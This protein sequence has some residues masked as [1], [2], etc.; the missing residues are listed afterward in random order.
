MLINLLKKHYKLFTIYLIFTIAIVLCAIIK[1]DYDVIIPAG[2]ED[3]GNAIV[4]TG[5]SDSGIDINTVSVYSYSKIS[6][7]DYLCAKLNKNDTVEK[8]YEYNVTDLDLVY[9]SGNIQKKVSINNSIIAGYKAAGCEIEYT[10]INTNGCII[11][12]LATYAPKELQIGD[13]I[14]AVNGEA[15]TDKVSVSVLIRKMVDFSY[16][17]VDEKVLVEEEGLKEYPTIFTV[18]RKGTKQNITCYPYAYSN[19]Y[20]DNNNVCK[21]PL[22]GISIYE[23]NIIKSTNPEYKI[24]PVSS[25]GPSGGL[26]QSFYVYEVLTGGKLSKDLKIVGTGTVDKDGNAGAIGGIYQKVIA[27]HLNKADIFFVP[28]SSMDKE[29]YSKESNYTEA[30]ASY[31][32]LGNTKMKLVPVASLNDIIEYLTNYQGGK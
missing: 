1:V 5:K 2:T 23:Y 3:V 13:Q 16:T 10:D 17:G 14:L 28:V 4:I 32:K 19:V 9:S 15:V 22:F 12:T 31:E 24:L 25:I 29:V 6:V 21:Y 20:D 27:A 7:L 18:L 8:T 30:Y 26:M 11:H